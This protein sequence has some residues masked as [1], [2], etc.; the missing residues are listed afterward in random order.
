[1]KRTRLGNEQLKR[2]LG[3]FTAIALLLL[4]RTLVYGQDFNTCFPC[5]DTSVSDPGRRV[6]HSF[7]L[8]NP[9]Y[10]CVVQEIDLSRNFTDDAILLSPADQVYVGGFYSSS[11]VVDARPQELV[12][13]RKPITISVSLPGLGNNSMTVESP[14]RSSVAAAIDAILATAGT[15]S[16]NPLRILFNFTTYYSEEQTKID[17]GL[18]GSGS[19]WNASAGFGRIRAKDEHSIFL[20]VLEPYYTVAIDQPQHPA[21]LVGTEVDC[22]AIRSQ[23]RTV[24]DAPVLAMSCTYG[25]AIFYELTQITTTNDTTADAKLSSAF[26]SVLL[27]GQVSDE[28][29]RMLNQTQ[30]R[31]LVLGGDPHAADKLMDLDGA[32]K[33]YQDGLQWSHQSPGFPLFFA[34]HCL[35]PGFPQFSYSKSTKFTAM[36]CDKDKGDG[37]YQIYLFGWDNGH[38]NTYVLYP[39]GSP[40]SPAGLPGA[41][42]S[43]WGSAQLSGAGNGTLSFNYDRDYNVYL[44]TYLYVNTPTQIDFSWNADVGFL[45]LNGNTI[46]NHSQRLF[47]R[48]GVN[49]LVIT[50]YNQHQSSHFTVSSPIQNEVEWMNHAPPGPLLAVDKER[51]DVTVD[52]GG[53]EASAELSVGNIGTGTMNYAITSSEFWIASD[54]ASGN[55]TEGGSSARHHI[56]LDTTNLLAGRH[57]AT[58]RVSAN[59]DET[60]GQV[61][62]IPLTVDVTPPHVWIDE[63]SIVLHEQDFGKITLHRDG[64]LSSPLAVQLT[65]GGVL[66]ESDLK[67]FKS[68]VRFSANSSDVS[69]DLVGSG[70]AGHAGEKDG[71]VAVVPTPGY[72]IKGAGAVGVTILESEPSVRISGTPSG[73]RIEWD[74]VS[75]VLESTEDLVSARWKV[76]SIIDGASTQ[77]APGASKK[78]FRIRRP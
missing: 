23:L 66:G 57:L 77:V 26:Q 13:S 6:T 62:E 29:R 10:S 52:E 16:V 25:R 33:L 21:D 34:Y 45:Y 53:G 54:P 55:I 78:F 3:R 58:I 17:L 4:G 38:D 47:L 35:R 64:V 18:T 46:D 73:V 51:I 43:P 20:T 60:E 56:R 19:G 69:L 59:S 9:P 37:L 39:D 40:H 1:M 74:I 8:L 72:R 42:G 76:E 61:L 2:F 49:H 28:E 32:Q 15:N 7:P 31:A 75:A 44:E 65:V 41:S 63:E 36:S 70:G 24:I 5:I 48:Q 30:I 11:T 22:P 14:S 27:G 67:Y 50:G 12:V 71:W 68:T